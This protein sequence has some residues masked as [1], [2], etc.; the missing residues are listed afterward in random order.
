[1]LQVNDTLC[2]TGEAVN[3]YEWT[4]PQATSQTYSIY[5]TFQLPT[6]FDG[7]IDDNTIT[8]DARTT[9]TT[10]ADV[11]Y[12]VFRSTGSAITECG[13]DTTVTTANNTWQTVQH[14]GNEATVCSFA[15]GDRVIFKLNMTARNN[16]SVYV[17]DINFTYTND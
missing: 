13:S 12:E 2:D 3:Y 7:F 8:L 6:T 14:G 16:D 5:L 1:M 9:D 17:S 15:A 11:T 4:S 10:D